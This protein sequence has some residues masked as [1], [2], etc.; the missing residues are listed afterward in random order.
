M[1]SEFG[2]RLKALRQIRFTRRASTI[3]SSM[4]EDTR[5]KPVAALNYLY[6]GLIFSLGF[7]RPNLN[8]LG[9]AVQATDAIFVAAALLFATVVASRRI[10]LQY[11]PL[12][13]P[14]GLYLAA[15]AASAI[16]SERPDFSFIKLLGEI[17]LVGLAL[18]TIQ[19]IRNCDVIR[20]VVITW[21]GAGSLVGMVG[22]AAVVLF[23]V[24]R[25]NSVLILILHHY[26]SLPP[27]NYPRIQ[28]TFIYPAMLCNY[29]TVSLMF[30]FAAKRLGWIRPALFWLLLIVQIIAA[31]FTLTPG[32]GG[33]VLAVSLWIALISGEDP[34]KITRRIFIAAGSGL[35]LLSIGV[36]AFTLRHI[37]TS[38]YSFDLLGVRIDP[39]QRLLTWQGALETLFQFPILGRG[40]GLG[41]ANV[42]F[43][44]PSGQNQLLTDAHNIW[45]NIAG[46]AGFFGLAAIG[47]FCIS[48]VRRFLPIKSG[49]DP[50]S[51]LP[52]ASGIAFISIFLVQGLVGSFE[53]A[54][55]LWVL[56]GIIAATSS[57][58]AVNE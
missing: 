54:R 38:P 50:R 3:A 4:I 2:I 41:V 44:A 49:S 30:L 9:L 21:I 20:R 51:V 42:R 34:G 17:Y 12:M 57:I 48:I 35:A 37:P 15:L 18:L 6:L 40:L 24:D 52:A 56:I 19:I 46:Q 7:M 26:G 22:V 47:V 23:Y 45:L 33:F 55:H 36:S 25:E 27:G 28:S 8:L 53:D 32:L 14:M 31:V 43:L 13:V 10:R 11:D 39:T 29:L 16:F 58:T 5:S 1:R